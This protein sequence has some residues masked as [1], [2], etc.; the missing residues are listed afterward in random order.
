MTLKYAEGKPGNKFVAAM[1]AIGLGSA[2]RQH[3]AKGCRCHHKGPAVVI[4]RSLELMVKAAAHEAGIM[5]MTDY[6]GGMIAIYPA[7]P[8]GEP[9]ED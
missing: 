3:E 8:S 1:E 6:I 4:D 9:L 2:L 5:V 7:I